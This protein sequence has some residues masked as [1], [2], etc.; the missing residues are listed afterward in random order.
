MKTFFLL[1]GLLLATFNISA[2][3]DIAASCCNGD[4]STSRIEIVV[5][6]YINEQ[7]K[8]IT[9]IIYQILENAEYK[10]I[11]LIFDKGTY[12]FYNDKAVGKYHAITNHDNIYRYFAFPLINASNVEIDGNGSEFIFHGVMTPFVVE[13]SNNIRIKNISIDWEEPF[14]LQAEV[15]ANNIEKS[16]VDLRVNPMTETQFEGSRLGFKSNG[17]EHYFLGETMV[18]DPTTK[19]VAYRAADYLI[20]GVSARSTFDKK[21]DDSTFRIRAN[22]AQK[23]AP[24]GMVYVFKGPNKSNRYAPAIHLVSS[25]NIKIDSLNIYHAGGMGIIGEKTENIHINKVDVKLREGS[26]RM[27]TTTADATHFCNCRGELIIE[28]CLFENMLDDATNVHGTYIKI[29]E[30][31]DEYTVHAGV[32]HHQQYD[33]NFAE[34]GDDVQ[35]I[36]YET[37]LPIVG[38]KVASFKRIN[39]RL[40]E[41]KFTTKIPATL[42]VNDAI[43]N[44]SWYPVTTLRNN[45][46]RNNRARSFLISTRN[47]TI[48]ENNTFSSMMSSILVEGDLNHWYESGSVDNLIIRNNTFYDCVYGGGRGS[49]IWINPRMKSNVVGEQ[50]EKNVVIEN[51]IFRTFDNSILDANSV[52]GLVFRNNEIEDSNTYPKI[53]TKLPVIRVVNSQNCVV[54][55]NSYS[56]NAKVKVEFDKETISTL[57][58]DK[59]QKGLTK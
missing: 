57:K 23:P 42:K 32:N 16:S 28:N 49:I 1:L 50:Y 45:V 2:Q 36:T 19:A 29:S 27:V 53:W 39:E 21:L 9:P 52:D 7:T 12:H 59:K 6:D 10:D 40:F 30:I 48:I 47:R 46:V 56:G 58:F 13:N 41:V 38:A 37:L 5:N 18:F 17:Q 24:L 8:D 25:K 4:I 34:R 26:D 11:K 14:Y 43:D 22:F 44:I 31:I 33:Y 51:N 15:V 20:G 54:E 35:F 55:N 3:H